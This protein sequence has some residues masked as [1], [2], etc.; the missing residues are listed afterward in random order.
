M[1]VGTEW[2]ALGTAFIL[3]FLHALE[4]DHIVAVTAFVATRP[5]LAGAVQFGLRWGL[6]HSAAVLAAGAILLLSGLRWSA[7]YD[8]WGEAVVGVMLVAVGLWAIRTARRLHAH[9]PAEHGNHG[10]L[11]A[12]A[13][14]DAPHD[15]PHQHGAPAT[16]RH[17]HRRGITVV[18]LV[19]GLAGTSAVV[20][21][22]PV[23]M[24]DRT[25]I[26]IG[27]LLTFGAGTILAMA[28][29]AMV[30]AMA[31]RTAAARSLALGRRMGGAAGVAGIAVG[32]WWILRALG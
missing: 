16:G 28:L 29:F 24:V 14:G 18:G 10:H 19:H 1:P 31:M 11:H 12:H 22:V 9:P 23:T 20:A 17:S 26:G 5:A 3:G 15:H 27:Y 30:A 8:A 21:L 7:R 6:G 25:A 2:L 4:I 32:A 13:P